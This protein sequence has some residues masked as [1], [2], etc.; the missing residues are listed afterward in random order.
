MAPVA[1]CRHDAL[2]QQGDGGPWKRLLIMHWLQGKGEIVNR[3]DSKIK[4]VL[5]KLKQTG[6]W[7][8][9]DVWKYRK[10]AAS[11]LVLPLSC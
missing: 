9:D 6:I 7:L 4:L 8:P 1:R 10:L 11:V 5:G 3:T 2:L